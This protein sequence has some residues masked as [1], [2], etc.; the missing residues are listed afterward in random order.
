[1]AISRTQGVGFSQIYSPPTPGSPTATVGTMGE[2]T[3]W[4]RSVLDA[5]LMMRNR[6]PSAEYP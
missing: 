5:R 6:I 2:G 1:M 3:V 4:A